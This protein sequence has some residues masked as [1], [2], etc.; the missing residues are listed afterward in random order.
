MGGRAPAAWHQVVRIVEDVRA[1][2]YVWP[3]P[4]EA[5]AAKAAGRG[6]CASKHAL[7]AEELAALGVGSR[8]LLAVGPL[9]PA[10]LVDRAPF[11]VGAHLLEV[12]E[13]LTVSV[14][15]VGPVVV[16][17][18]WDPP[19]VARGLPGVDRWDGRSDLPVAV[20]PPL[21][22][23]APDPARL[24]AE[25]EALRGRLYRGDDRAVRDRVLRDLSDEFAR[26]RAGTA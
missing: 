21:A 11:A 7:V 25:K 16:D 19:L 9:V 13:Y 17:V 24:R 3:G 10:S 20:G 23:W 5:R 2:P 1:L 4:P 18:T 22:S 15:G 14:P 12:H 8:P 6:T 26:W